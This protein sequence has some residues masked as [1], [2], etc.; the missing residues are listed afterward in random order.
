MVH[1]GIQSPNT[2]DWL[3]YRDGAARLL[4][5]GS[6]YDPIQ[7]F[8]YLLDEMAWGAGFVYPP[9]AAVVFI[10]TLAGDWTFGLLNVLGAMA[11]VSVAAAIAHRDG[12]PWHWVAVIAALAMAHPG[13][14]EMRE[15][16]ISPLLAASVGAMWLAPRASGWL[17]VIGGMIKVYPLLGLVWA[18]REGAPLV[19][20]IVV[21]A[22]LVALT[23][24]LW[25][26]W[27]NAMLNA[28]P[29]CP[30]R[31]LSLGSLACATELP[32]SGYIV[33]LLLALA[34]WRVRSDRVAFLLITVAMV[35]P[36]PDIYWG[37]LM[38]PFI[39]A[40]PIVCALLRQLLNRGRDRMCVAPVAAG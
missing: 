2:A 31:S 33:S 12:L 22:T 1:Y 27:V 6:P 11:F 24:W 29:S 15:G 9:P 7:R 26:D 38:V 34:A 30:E 37:Y 14:R 28:R 4:E 39:G 21:G 40:L 23:F 19:R 35:A 13:F 32:M 8:P 17:V 25:P 5:T 20:P 36:A 16:Q 10:F 3:S 18:V